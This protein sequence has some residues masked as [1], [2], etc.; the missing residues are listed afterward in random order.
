MKEKLSKNEGEY[1]R[2]SPF[3]TVDDTGQGMRH[4]LPSFDK[5]YSIMS[6][7]RCKDS[8]MD[9]TKG[10]AKVTSQVTFVFIQRRLERTTKIRDTIRMKS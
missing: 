5:R 4:S 3:S 1:R 9:D 6:E 8:G 2:I 10:S 7:D